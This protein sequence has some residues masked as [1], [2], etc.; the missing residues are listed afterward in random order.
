MP[1]AAAIAQ[2]DIV[3]AKI[4][5]F[6]PAAITLERSRQQMLNV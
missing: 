4:G 3:Y 2:P 5:I 6:F 1:A